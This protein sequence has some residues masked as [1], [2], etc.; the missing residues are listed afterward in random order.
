MDGK[1]NNLSREQIIGKAIAIMSST[2]A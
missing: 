1:L 2:A